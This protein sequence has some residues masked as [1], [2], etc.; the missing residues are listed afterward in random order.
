MSGPRLWPVHSNGFGAGVLNLAAL[1][2][3]NVW[4]LMIAGFGGIGFVLRKTRLNM[5]VGLKYATVKGPF[6]TLT[7]GYVHTA[8]LK[9][10]RTRASRSG[11]RFA[12]S[13][14][15]CVIAIDG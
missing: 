13:V 10:T 1:P 4:F 15:S 9:V 3:P 7:A 8:P 5:L 12:R 11:C 14:Q 6:K 2:E